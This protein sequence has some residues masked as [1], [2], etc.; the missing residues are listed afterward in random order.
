MTNVFI[1][2]PTEMTIS[3]DMLNKLAEDLR[4]IY[5]LT[6]KFFFRQDERNNDAKFL[7]DNLQYDP[8]SVIALAIDKFVMPLY[9]KDAMETEI[10]PMLREYSD[11]T[12]F[13]VLATYVI[14]LLQKAQ[15]SL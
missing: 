7:A 11:H 10:V 3:K 12:S 4:D 15:E 2:T 8:L 1:V 9:G 14:P 13:E 5:G 6:D